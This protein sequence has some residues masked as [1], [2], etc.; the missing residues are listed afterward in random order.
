MRRARQCWIATQCTRSRMHRSQR[1]GRSCRQ[2]QPHWLHRVSRSS[3][4]FP[5]LILYAISRSRMVQPVKSVQQ[6]M[7][8]T[9]L[10]TSGLTTVW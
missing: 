2:L 10:Q 1:M 4:L 9:C 8:K 5:L 3:R 6:A 7:S